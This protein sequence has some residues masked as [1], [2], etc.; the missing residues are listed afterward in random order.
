MTWATSEKEA[1]IELI[2]PDGRVIR[3]GHGRYAPEAPA[4]PAGRSGPV[5]RRRRLRPAFDQL[6]GRA[7]DISA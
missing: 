5:E 1:T 4:A 2:L 3:L 7:F 6:R